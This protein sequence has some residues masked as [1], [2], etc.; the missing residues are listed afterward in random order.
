MYLLVLMIAFFGLGSACSFASTYSTGE[1]LFKWDKKE[2]VVC[3]QDDSPIKQHEFSESDFEKLSSYSEIVIP[4][5][6]LKKQIQTLIQ[7]EF[8]LETTGI[9]FSGWQPCKG[10]KDYDLIIITS[11]LQWGAIDGEAPIGRGD[12][13]DSSVKKKTLKNYVYLNLYERETISISTREFVLMT[14]L[15]EFGH[16]AGLKHEHIR[17]TET[18]GCLIMRES[19]GKNTAFFS[20]YDPSSIMNYCYTEFI[21]WIAGFNFYRNEGMDASANQKRL[22]QDIDLLP[23]SGAWPYTDDSIF[24][25][26]TV[27]GIKGLLK[28]QVRIG[29][30]KGDVHGLR[31]MYVYDRAMRRKICHEDFNLE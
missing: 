12:D 17:Y 24:T 31:C 28:Y 20:A 22:K 25:K 19:S 29:L 14:T 16:A 13:E 6:A 3:W 30:S 4:G 10:L 8:T 18:H 15:H 1:D 21:S 11:N 27:P 5:S 7:T 2:V 23:W 26:E 9:R